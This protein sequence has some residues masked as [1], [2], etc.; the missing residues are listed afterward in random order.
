MRIFISTLAVLS[1]LLGVAI[2]G[3]GLWATVGLLWKLRALDDLLML[4]VVLPLLCF[5]AIAV[6]IGVKFLIH[7]NT[8]KAKG[9]AGLGGFLVWIS[10]NTRSTSRDVDFLEGRLYMLYA[11]GPI[12]CGLLTYQ[13]LFWL[14]RRSLEGKPRNS[15][16]TDLG[17]EF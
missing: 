10:F 13:I 8:A 3:M 9:V 16:E 17:P 14:F 2:G 12:V 7:Q 5:G 6:I 1:I 15:E 11:L 4:L